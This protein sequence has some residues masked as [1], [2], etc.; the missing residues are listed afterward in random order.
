MTFYNNSG[1]ATAYLDDDLTHIYLFDGTPVAYL[2]NNMVYG[3]NGHQFGWF[4]NGWIRD[5]NG[6]CVFFTKDAFGPGPIKPIKK[7]NPIKSIK[8]IKPVKCVREI[9]RLKAISSLSWS[10][11]SGKQF[12]GQ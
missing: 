5:L 6:D 11:F 3:F 9:K 7:M 8:H 2:V 1:E 4:E 12:F 10:T